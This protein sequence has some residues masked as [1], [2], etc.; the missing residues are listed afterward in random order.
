MRRLLA[1]ASLTLLLA[2]CASTPDLPPSAGFAQVEFAGE[3]ATPGSQQLLLWHDGRLYYA[4]GDGSV[5]V[6][7]EKG[8][9]L[10]RLQAKD[11]KG[12]PVLK[13]PA[14][15]TVG[16]DTVYVVDSEKD[17]VA[18]FSSDGSY[19]GSFGSDGSG[20]G[21][22]SSPK[23]VDFYDGVLYV[24][25][26]GNGRI[27]LYGDSGVFLAT[28]EIE[29]EGVNKKADKADKPYKLDEP[30][31][32]DVDTL[33]RIHVRDGG[34]GLIKRYSQ[35]GVY[36]GHLAVEGKPIAFRVAP[37]GIYVADLASY[38][39]QK[40][41]EDGTLA[42]YFGSKG[43]GP[44]QFMSMAGIAFDGERRIFVGDA[45]EG[46]ADLFVAEVPRKRPQGERDIARN[47]VRTLSGTDVN[48]RHLA[49]DGRD[50]LYAVAEDGKS[51]N[52]IQGGR[53]TGRIKPRGV[54][55]GAI[56]VDPDGGLWAVDREK[57]RIVQ[58][59]ETGAVIT[60]FGSEGSGAGQL[61]EPS[62]LAI[63]SNG[64]LFIAD[65]GNEWVQAMSREGVFLSALREGKGEEFDEPERIALDPQDN[66]YVLDTGRDRITRFSAR[67]R[68][69]AEFGGDEEKGVELSR[70]RDLVATGDEVLL[71]DGDSVLAFS[72]KGGFLRRFGAEGSGVGELSEPEAITLIDASRFAVAEGGNKRV[73]AFATLNKPA[74]PSGLKAENGIH[75]ATLSWDDPGLA[76]IN[77]YVIYRA[78]TAEGP[79]RVAGVSG[80]NRYEDRGLPA[81]RTFHYRVAAENDFGY[82][83]PMGESASASTRIFSPSRIESIAVEPDAWSLT[84]SWEPEE[85]DY[86]EEY[87]IY[88]KR[89]GELL[90]VDKSNVPSY[91]GSSL[92]PNNEYTYYVS[93]LSID[94]I[95]SEKQVVTARTLAHYRA[96]LEL[97]TS[98]LS[99]IF[100]NSYKVYERDGLGT[101]TLSN[102]TGAPMENIKVAFTI[103]EFM[104]FP[105][106]TRVE[107]IE[108]GESAEVT[109][110]AV[111]NNKILTVTEDT[112]VQTE[113]VATYF[114]D[115]EEKRFSNTQSINV[116]EKHRLSWSQPKRFAAFV[117]PKDPVVLDYSRAVA[118]QFADEH[119]P[120]QWAADIFVALGLSGITYIP[121]PT[122]PYQE[123]SGNVDFVDYIQYPRETLERKSGDCDDLVALYSSALE[124]MGIT[125]RV[126]EVPG[127]MLM[128]ISTGI[129]ADET[130]DTLDNMYVIHDEVL[131]IPVEATLIG[132]SFIRAWE[133]GSETYYKWLDKGL[134]LLNVH[135]AWRSFK[136]ANLPEP[137]WK[138]TVIKRELIEERYPEQ[139]A[140]LVRLISRVRM[141]PY[142]KA[143]EA[144]PDDVTAMVR[145]GIV[146]ARSG[147]VEAAQNYFAEALKREPANAR[148]L[149]NRAN[150]LYMQE[151]YEKAAAAYEEAA[152]ADPNDAMIRINQV[153]AY[154]AMKATDKAAEAFRKAEEIEPEIGKRFRTMAIELDGK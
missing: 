96:P 57:L 52:R 61:D 92:T 41:D 94:G 87:R 6:A 29:E 2:S 128:M 141:R 62:D 34:D 120:L 5:Q 80:T 3:I 108:P 114:D 38:T 75:G 116:Y 71:L 8:N 85:L 122:N 82:Q 36:L 60:A 81:N 72:D 101:L 109:L 150:L 77:R 14:A 127:H 125:T 65:P 27:Q 22:L 106:E 73:Q 69:V 15:V 123:T 47:S 144:N 153:R 50:T 78:E 23:G 32:I 91:T 137:Q 86:V 74:A 132:K 63:A 76:Y 19:R 13:A 110:K 30:L 64:I 89:D 138:P 134:S 66:L 24:A 11:A 102:N 146:S 43:K 115:G 103:K 28:L 46:V 56:A 126:V 25:D 39:V 33:G 58:L 1:A 147:D 131:W 151:Q 12:D 100:S 18:M 104:D 42:Y 107:R 49:W 88:Q 95:E 84:L 79:Y 154:K 51:I 112:P 20:R 119:E 93:V 133:V 143:L 90:Q 48:A 136:P 135:Q 70:P 117:T 37:D 129:P 148:A 124:S 21:R 9:M 97:T 59:D 7:D 35:K 45:E 145:A 98:D 68:V 53:V 55:A 113:L 111:F 118:T 26:S 4:R 83:G 140:T 31:D 105:T 54:E 99:D 44:S 16:D 139:Q 67:G 152:A 10:A 17:R 149:N 40:F 121:D 130:G 142:L